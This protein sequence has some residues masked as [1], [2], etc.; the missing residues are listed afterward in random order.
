MAVQNLLEKM[1]YKSIKHWIIYSTEE[2]IKTGI[3]SL[4]ALVGYMRDHFVSVQL[5]LAQNL[6]KTKLLFIRSSTPLQRSLMNTCYVLY[7]R[8]VKK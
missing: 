5:I 4:G 3:A 7:Q 1:K 6:Y 2:A 8:R